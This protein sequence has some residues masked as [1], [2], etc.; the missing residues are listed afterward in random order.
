MAEQIRDGFSIVS[1]PDGFCEDHGD[2]N[3]LGR[4]GEHQVSIQT[5]MIDWSLQ[6]LMSS[7]MRVLPLKTV[8]CAVFPSEPTTSCSS[9]SHFKYNQ[10]L[11]SQNANGGNT[12]LTHQDGGGLAFKN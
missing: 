12:L 3:H 7:P 6:T 4:Q 9:F 1:S 8:H 10:P 11:K 5:E 2:V